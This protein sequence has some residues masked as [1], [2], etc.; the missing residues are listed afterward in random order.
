MVPFFEK[1][2]LFSF[3]AIFLLTICRW[4]DV[5]ELSI[6]EHW[7]AVGLFIFINIFNPICIKQAKSWYILTAANRIPYKYYVLWSILFSHSCL[8]VLIAYFKKTYS[9]FLFICLFRL[10]YL[11]HQSTHFGLLFVSSHSFQ[12]YLKF[13]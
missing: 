5:Q 2:F 13:I 10:Y 8:V 1:I 4:F 9:C 7:A 12:N 3:L 6:V 11:I